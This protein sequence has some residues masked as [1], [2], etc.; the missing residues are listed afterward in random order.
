MQG[1]I[2]QG[3]SRQPFRAGEGGVG[4]GRGGAGWGGGGGCMGG[5][6]RRGCELGR[7]KEEG[8]G[9]KTKTKNLPKEVPSRAGVSCNLRCEPH[10]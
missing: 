7:H 10:T 4:A 2:S 8:A 1:D 3:K 6:V 5:R 9:P